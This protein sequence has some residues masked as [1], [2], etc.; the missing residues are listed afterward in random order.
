M[1]SIKRFS[2]SF[3]LLCVIYLHAQ[4]KKKIEHDKNDK[5]ASRVFSPNFLISN[6]ACLS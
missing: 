3:S 5:Y 6:I 2:F 4:T 1:N